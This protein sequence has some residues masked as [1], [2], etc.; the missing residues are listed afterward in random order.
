MFARLNIRHGPNTEQV[1]REL[2]TGDPVAEFD[3]A[4][5]N[6]NERRIEAL[7][8]DL[9]IDRPAMNRIVFTDVTFARYP[10]AE[11]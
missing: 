4:C 6:V 10:R 3:L 5:T 2:A 7:W 1:V 9:I 8:L 11:I